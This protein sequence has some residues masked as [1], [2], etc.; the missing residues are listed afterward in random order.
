MDIRNIDP[1][2]QYQVELKEKVTLYG[3]VFYPGHDLTLRGDALKSVVD[4]VAS[5]TRLDQPV[6]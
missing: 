5:A 4:K 6:A 2:A 3:Q 1:A